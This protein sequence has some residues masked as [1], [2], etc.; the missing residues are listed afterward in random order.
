MCKMLYKWLTNNKKIIEPGWANA[1]EYKYLGP[2]RGME[3]C[4]NIVPF[5]IAHGAIDGQAIYAVKI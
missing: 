2:F 1:W 4:H 3:L 5:V